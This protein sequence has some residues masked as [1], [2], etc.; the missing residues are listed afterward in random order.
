MV[1]TVDSKKG[2]RCSRPPV[3]LD[4]PFVG[5]TGKLAFVCENTVFWTG[6]VP[7]I[8]RKHVHF[9]LR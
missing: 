9:D 1:D 4:D 6:H 8:C 2:R 3:S 5:P 7:V